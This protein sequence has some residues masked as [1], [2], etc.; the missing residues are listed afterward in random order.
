VRERRKYWKRPGFAESAVY[1]MR[2]KEKKSLKL[3]E[4]FGF[5]SLAVILSL[6][7][8]VVSVVF[9]DAFFNLFYSFLKEEKKPEIIWVDNLVQITTPK[10][11]KDDGRYLNFLCNSVLYG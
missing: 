7:L 8:A 9:S 2:K 1:L 10:T 3:K 5:F 4:R 6:I 11:R